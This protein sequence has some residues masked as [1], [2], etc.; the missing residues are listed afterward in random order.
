MLHELRAARLHALQGRQG[1]A[2]RG[3]GRGG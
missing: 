1:R 3:R 2:Q